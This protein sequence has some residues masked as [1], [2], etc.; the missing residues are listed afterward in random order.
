[1]TSIDEIPDPALKIL[2]TLLRHRVSELRSKNVSDQ[3]IF[4]RIEIAPAIDLLSAKA[5]EALNS[6]L[7]G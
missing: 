2:A 3:L 6:I 4:S 5:P 7:K 1:M